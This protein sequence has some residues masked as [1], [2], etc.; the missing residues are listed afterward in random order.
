MTVTYEVADRIATVTIDRPDARNSMDLATLDALKQA[1]ARSETDDDVDVVVLTATGTVFSAGLDL[2]SLSSG[3]IDVA[4]HTVLGNPWVEHAKPRIAAVNG[5]AITGG[6]ELVLNCDIAVAS[7][8]ASFAD[9]HTRVGILPFW[10]MSV[11]LPR[12]VGRRNAAVMSLT[13]NFVDAGTAKAWGLVFDVVEPEALTARSRSLAA[14]IVANDQ[15]G[16]RAMLALYRDGAGLA[17]T[18]AQ[19]LEVQRA[20]DWHSDGFDASAI[21]RRFEAIKQRGRAQSSRRNDR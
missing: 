3:E 2:K 13:G 17:D 11:L 8:A 14:D 7:T 9:T 20:T 18:D 21:A 1:M 15:P 4:A 19:A 6:L 12:A 16:V 10:G 5:P